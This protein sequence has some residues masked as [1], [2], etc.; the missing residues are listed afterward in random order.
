METKNLASIYK[1]V[2]NEISE[3]FGKDKYISLKTKMGVD[4]ISQL[5]DIYQNVKNKNSKIF[6]LDEKLILDRAIEIIS[7]Y[8]KH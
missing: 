5:I 7:S 8:R 1:N 6:S 3:H 4:G 2:E